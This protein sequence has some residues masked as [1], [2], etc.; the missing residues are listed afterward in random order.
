M[1]KRKVLFGALLI[2]F[3]GLGACGHTGGQRRDYARDNLK[4][5]PL[6]AEIK[7]V[8]TPVKNHQT[9][10]VSTAL[11]NFGSKV[12]M[13]EVL[14]C[15]YSN[16]WNSDNPSIVTGESCLN[17]SVAK[18]YLKPGETF[19]KTVPV[20]V[21]LAAGKAQPESVTFRLGFKDP[22]CWSAQGIPP[23]WSNSITV[24]VTR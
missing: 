14:A 22:T 12:W 3:S 1:H 9:F 2:C 20:R 19:E 23:N 18:I 13:L 24:S 10:P 4:A 16:Q 17:N 21:E 7:L 15:G 11:S 5:S 6:K 8:Q